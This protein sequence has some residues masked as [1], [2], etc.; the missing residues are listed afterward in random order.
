MNWGDFCTL[1]SPLSPSRRERREKIEQQLKDK[2]AEV[3]V[4]MERWGRER[5]QLEDLKEARSKLDRY[6]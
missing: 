5:S 3:D 4:L 2:Q 6:V 1:Y